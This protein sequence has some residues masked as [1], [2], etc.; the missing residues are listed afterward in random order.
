LADDLDECI[1][2][3]IQTTDELENANDLLIEERQLI[4]E[5]QLLNGELTNT[6]TS[7][8]GQL[9]TTETLLSESLQR[10]K[11]LRNQRWWIGAV[12]FLLGGAVGLTLGHF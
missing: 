1:D 7:R 6:L 10:E 12:A 2:R 3:L 8:D 5:L 4:D 11:S 9:T